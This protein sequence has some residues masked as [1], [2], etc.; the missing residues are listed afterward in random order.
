MRPLDDTSGLPVNRA[1]VPVALGTKSGSKSYYCG[2]RLGLDLIPGSDGQCGPNNGPQCPDC[3]GFDISNPPPMKQKSD[4]ASNSYSFGNCRLTAI[5]IMGNPKIC[6]I[7]IEA[8]MLKSKEIS[9]KN[10]VE[11]NENEDWNST[12]TTN[13]PLSNSNLHW[14]EINV[15]SSFN[16][17]ELLLKYNLRA[18]ANSPSV[19]RVKIDG[20][21]VYAF[22]NSNK[23]KPLEINNF[24]SVIK[25][26]D[27]DA[28]LMPTSSFQKFRVEFLMLDKKKIAVTTDGYCSI[29]QLMVKG[30]KKLPK[31]KHHEHHLFLVKDSKR[32]CDVCFLTDDTVDETFY[33]CAACDFDLCGRCFAKEIRAEETGQSARIPEGKEVM[34][35]RSCIDFDGLRQGD[36]G[37]LIDDDSSLLPYKVQLPPKESNIGTKWYK[38]TDLVPADGNSTYIKINRSSLHAHDL[39]KSSERG[40]EGSCDI[41]RKDSSSE[42]FC[43]PCNWDICLD[44]FYMNPFNF[45]EIVKSIHH[46]HNL[47]KTPLE[48]TF[49]SE[50]SFDSI[51]VREDRSSSSSTVATLRRSRQE[52]VKVQQVKNGWALL[53]FTE[54]SYIQS[55]D[56][57]KPGVSLCYCKVGLSAD[58]QSLVFLEDSASEAVDLSF[59]SC[60]VCH[61][62]S[63]GISHV[64]I[65]DHKFDFALCDNCF[66][67]EFQNMIPKSLNSQFPRGTRVQVCYRLCLFL[68]YLYLQHKDLC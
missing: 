53:D 11:D 4:N 14:F 33:S 64:C 55:C 63:E 60:G 16:W 57:F 59:P 66:N 13:H 67:D 8:D 7:P 18:T 27:L 61:K 15:P 50:Q 54:L 36:V 2:R 45:N 3:N 38:L 35:S 6:N 44:C 34:L 9:V 51:T 30:F 28:A 23:P 56:D 22:N 43:G 12:V 17:T 62:E 58:Q 41:C 1:N 25:R 47:V 42:F 37:L 31:S 32:I 65:S 29:N 52:P 48:V 46:N 19:Y 26:E 40:R 5:K 20:G 21:K 39:L 68:S 10:L 49:P 24:T